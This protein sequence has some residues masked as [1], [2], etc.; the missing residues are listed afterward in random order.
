M[1]LTILH[2]DRIES[3]VH[4]TRNERCEPVDNVCSGFFF[5]GCDGSEGDLSRLADDNWEQ[6]K[7]SKSPRSG[8]GQA[9]YLGR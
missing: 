5:R 4:R 2:V 1:K 8:I 6:K 9:F 7:T 3:K